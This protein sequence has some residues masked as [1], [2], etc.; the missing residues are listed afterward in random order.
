MN[1]NGIECELPQAEATALS[2][3]GVVKG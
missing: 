3:L 2:R 1:T